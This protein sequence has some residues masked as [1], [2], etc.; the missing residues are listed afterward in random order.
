MFTAT[1]LNALHPSPGPCD[2]LVMQ[3]ARHLSIHGRVQGV[4][5]RG[6]AVQAAHELGLSGWVRNRCDGTV[7]AVVQGA[8]AD[9]ERFIALARRGPAA[10]AVERIAAAPIDVDPGLTGFTQQ[11]TA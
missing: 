11:P 8:E 7:E 4:F 10:A 2:N 9:I 5:Y 6:W 3:V 1:N